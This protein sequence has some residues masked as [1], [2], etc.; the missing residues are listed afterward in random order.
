VLDPLSEMVLSGAVRDGE[1]VPVT[2]TGSG[3]V[4]GGRAVDAAA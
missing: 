3:L 2:A 1:R 4:I